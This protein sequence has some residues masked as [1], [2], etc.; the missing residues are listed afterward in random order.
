[1]ERKSFLDQEA[2]ANY[3]AGSARG[4]IGF[5]TSTNDT[6]N[7]G[8]AILEN[9]EEEEEEEDQE[10]VAENRFTYSKKKQDEEDVE[11]DLI[12][13]QIEDKLSAKRKQ[14]TIN[15]PNINLPTQTKFQDLKR[16]LAS[17]TEDEWSMIP[18]PGDMTRRNKRQRILEQQSQRSYALPDSI[19]SNLGNPLSNLDSYL[20]K[21]SLDQST[22]DQI[23]SMSGS[24]Q[25]LKIGDLK[26]GRVIFSS[27]RK[28][29]PFKASSY[30]SSAKLEESYGHLNLARR[31]VQ[32]GCDKIP[33]NEELWL[34]NIR[35]NE[36]DRTLTAK[37]IKQALKYNKLSEKLWLKSFEFELDPISK[38][39]VL[40]K[41]LEELPDSVDLWRH[42]IEL[43]K[44]SELVRKLLLKAVDLCN[45]WEFWTA[46]IN[47]SSYNESK[48]LLNKVRNLL[49]GDLR[50]WVLGSKVEE[51]ENPNIIQSKLDKLITKGLKE[52]NEI[53]KS[54]IF[55]FSIE[56][57]DE[58]FSKTSVAILHGYLSNNKNID[59][60]ISDI[61]SQPTYISNI[62]LNYIIETKNDLNVWNKLFTICKD[63]ENY[64][65][66]FEYYQK[67]I[68]LNPSDVTLNLMYAKD[69]WLLG[70]QID[71]SREILNNIESKQPKNKSI[72][73]AKLNLEWS[74]KNYTKAQGYA[75]HLTINYPNLSAGIWYKYIH[76]LRCLEMPLDTILQVSYSALE[77]FKF[78]WKLELQRLQILKESNSDDFDKYA[79]SATITNATCSDIYIEYSRYYSHNPIKARSILEKGLIQ[80]PKS[81]PLIIEKIKFELK[82]NDYSNAKS[83]INKYIKL[84]P[85]CDKLWILNLKM[86]NKSQRKTLFTDA[87]KN[88]NNSPIILMFIGSS[89]WKDGKFEKARSWFDKA[90]EN[91]DSNGDIWAWI[92]NYIKKF[93][94]I[95]DLKAFVLK[96]ENKY[97]FD[98][99][100]SGDVFL[101]FKKGVKYFDKSA[102]ELLE[103]TSDYLLSGNF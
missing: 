73:F 32:E 64:D 68:K 84:H 20:P 76:I 34:E 80:I 99:V 85:D 71:K 41:G 23:L 81:I 18:E 62:M 5:S 38:K 53:D 57:N 37:L 102:R 40:M 55:K 65:K 8:V 2:P 103:L 49:I 97:R 12:Y 63:A 58:G 6:F 24:E 88:T 45:H 43:E 78:N 46:L 74:T 11:A 96:F 92:Y 50:V 77:Q 26:K 100:N 22:Q 36:S 4:A 61:D 15:N 3:V 10:E 44:D 13:Q 83:L 94:S 35:L 16:E 93:E 86:S 82:C 52:C 67:A 95:D 9:E 31:Y 87:L 89:F 59:G 72:K 101:K 29:E 19:V 56:A 30:I 98:K 90:L 42:L 25:D 33:R 48:K 39:K 69:I 21:T 47:L 7:K 17:L 60:I 75:E 1:M 28:S 79:N 70:H 91:D 14:P 27:L 51:R 54:Q 66:L